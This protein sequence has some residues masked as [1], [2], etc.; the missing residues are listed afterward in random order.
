MILRQF[1]PRSLTSPGDRVRRSTGGAPP[2]GITLGKILRLG[3]EQAGRA[4]PVAI[5]YDKAIWSGLSWAVGEIA[6]A[7]L[8]PGLALT[9][10]A[11]SSEPTPVR[12]E[13]AVHALA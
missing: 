5:T 1:E 10:T 13:V 9:L 2:H 12:L 3:A 11:S 4:I 8:R 6:A 7:D